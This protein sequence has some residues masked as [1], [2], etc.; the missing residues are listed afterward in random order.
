M[1]HIRHQITRHAPHRARTNTSRHTPTNLNG[2]PNRIHPRRRPVTRL[3]RPI[4]Q[5]SR[6][7]NTR[8]MYDKQPTRRERRT[9]LPTHAQNIHGRDENITITGNQTLGI[10]HMRT[11][12]VTH[13]RT[14]RTHRTRQRHPCSA[15]FLFPHRT[16]K[17]GNEDGRA[18]GFFTFLLPRPRLRDHTETTPSGRIDASTRRVPPL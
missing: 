17:K 11:P 16:Q 9:N 4:N 7:H 1:R 13:R 10:S 15:G 2:Q 14:H 18:G 8:N 3:P 6:I 5:H 12:C